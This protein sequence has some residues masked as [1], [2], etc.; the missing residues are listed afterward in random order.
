MPAPA[1]HTAPTSGSPG[2]PWLTSLPAQLHLTDPSHLDSEHQA[3]AQP[4]VE[5]DNQATRS[6]TVPRVKG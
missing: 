6:P 1:V 3:Q 4:D 2:T 5:P